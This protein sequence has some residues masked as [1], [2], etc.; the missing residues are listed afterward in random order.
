MAPRSSAST[1]FFIELRQLVSSRL[2]ETKPGF[3]K[4]TA[5]LYPIR[6]RKINPL[7]QDWFTL[8]L[9]FCSEYSMLKEKRWGPIVCSHMTS[10]SSVIGQKTQALSRK[11]NSIS[12]NAVYGL[13][14]FHL[15]FYLWLRLFRLFFSSRG[16]IRRLRLSIEFQPATLHAFQMTECKF[17]S[18]IK[19]R[20]SLV[21]FFSFHVKRNVI[22]RRRG[23]RDEGASLSVLLWR[24]K[25]RIE[26]S[27][28][29]SSA[30]WLTRAVCCV[31]L[32]QLSAGKAIRLN[33]GAPTSRSSVLKR[34][35]RS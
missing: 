4:R 23:G 30:R 11:A 31:W 34:K 17:R 13:D 32:R 8:A 33:K 10:F 2:R 28:E 27:A 15:R 35:A 26:T 9:H 20:T 22:N 24:R 3:F 14:S 12:G 16:L 7:Q 1:L 21:F 29:K 19:A 18:K 5:S 6:G 25:T